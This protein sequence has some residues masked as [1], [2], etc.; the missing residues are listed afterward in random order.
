MKGTFRRKNRKSWHLIKYRFVTGERD[1]NDSKVF[2]SETHT[3]DSV[4]N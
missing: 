2:F 3:E 1:K 4:L